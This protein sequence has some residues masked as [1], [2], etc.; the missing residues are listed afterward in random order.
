[1]SGKKYTRT[2]MHNGACATF[3][4]PEEKSKRSKEG[5]VKQR[6]SGV[7][8]SFGFGAW[9]NAAPGTILE[10]HTLMVARSEP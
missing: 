8:T 5:A 7:G 3:N 10:M 2:C 9:F 6:P 1:M 4:G